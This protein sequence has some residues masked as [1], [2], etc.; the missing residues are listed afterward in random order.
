[1]LEKLRHGLG[2]RNAARLGAVTRI[3]SEDREE[4]SH[5]ALVELIDHALEAGDT[6]GKITEEIE[7]IAVVGADVGIDVPDEDGIDGAEA[8]FGFV[9]KTIDGVF[10]LV[11]I[12]E[13]AVPDEELDLREDVLRPFEFGARVLRVTV[14]KQRA[15]AV[16]PGAKTFEPLRL[17]GR[18]VGAAEKD[19]A[20]RRRLGEGHDAG[21]RDEVVTGVPLVGGEGREDWECD[22]DENDE[23]TNERSDHEW[24]WL[25]GSYCER[26]CSVRK[27]VKPKGARGS[28]EEPRHLRD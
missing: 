5:V 22:G 13:A 9:E 10:V 3:P 2:G 18:R 4:D 16:A 24:A 14:A 20:R 7:L 28:T 25:L 17:R 23:C 12:V 1:L 15:A 26:G 19:F 21:V 6:A 11:G 27:K 8:R